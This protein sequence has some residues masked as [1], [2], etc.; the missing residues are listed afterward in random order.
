MA[1]LRRH[2]GNCCGMNHIYGFHGGDATNVR[3]LAERTNLG[4]R[5]NL[6]LE[7]ILSNAQTRENPGLVEELARLGYVFT[8]SWTGGHGTPVH[9]FLRARTRLP[10]S[11]AHFYNRWVDD[12]NGQLPHPDLGGDLPPLVNET[13][14]PQAGRFVALNYLQIG[15]RVRVNSPTSQLNG[16]VAHITRLYRDHYYN[17]WRAVLDVTTRNGNPGEISVHNL[18]R[19][20]A[21]DEAPVA[22][23]AP[24]VYRHP[25]HAQLTFAPARDE[26]V[27]ENP[28]QARRLI[29]SQFYCIFRESGNASRV[30]AS[31]EEGVQAYPRAT[32][33]HERKVYSDGEIVEG[34]V[35]HG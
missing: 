18:V 28:P 27:V 32:E 17:T 34:P 24:T 14:Q 12:F 5:G 2:G 7:V 29:L 6:Q 1:E 3:S 4:G 35:N 19:L 15:D 13:G 9:L 22:P 8:S 10:L 33:W 26:V 30:F 31:L 11:A 25:N 23:P 21:N 16:R 20:D